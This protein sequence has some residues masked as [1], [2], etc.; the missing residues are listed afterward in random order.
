M[1]DVRTIAIDSSSPLFDKHALFYKEF[2]SDFRQVRYFTLLVVQK[3]PVEIRELNLLEQQVSEILKNAIKHG[4]KNDPSKKVHV[5]FAFD[6]EQAR[7]IVQDEGEGF[8]DIEKWN[9][10]HKARTRC[11]VEQDFEKMEQYV[12]WRTEKS[13]DIDGGNALFAAMEYWDGGVVYTAERNCVAVMK[14]F[15]RRSRGMEI[16]A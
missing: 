15:P 6:P 1:D 10:F 7:L 16:P 2:P 13:D 12:S 5:W 8:K 9:E 3:A 4:N 11:F 14:R